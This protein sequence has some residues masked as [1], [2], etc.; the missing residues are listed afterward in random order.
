MTNKKVEIDDEVILLTIS[1]TYESDLEKE[2]PKKLYKITRQC[3]KAKLCRVQ[4]YKIVFS[5]YKKIV[6][7]IYAVDKWDTWKKAGDADF[8]DWDGT[9]TPC[10]GRVCFVGKVS[11]DEK[12]RKKY[13]DA[14]VSDD[15]LKTPY[16]VK[17]VH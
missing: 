9:N 2:N 10:D 16:P 15:C 5:V 13:L 14:D 6:K 1:K 17:Y 8:R 3:W 12:L 11:T 7:E 4:N